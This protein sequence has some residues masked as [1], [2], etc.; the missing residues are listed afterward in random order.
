MA[1]EVQHE[2]TH[3]YPPRY[4]VANTGN[5]GIREKGY[6]YLTKLESTKMDEINLI[7][8]P[9]SIFGLV[10]EDRVVI[11]SALQYLK[12]KKLS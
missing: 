6:Q 7:D 10:N 4:F 2:G 12:E 1:D 5:N 9:F 3:P 8:S 11:A